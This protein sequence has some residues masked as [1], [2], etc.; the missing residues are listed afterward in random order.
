MRNHLAIAMIIFGAMSFS[1]AYLTAQENKPNPEIIATLSGHSDLVYSV[2][3][4]PDSKQVATG[5]F[6]NT[7]KLWEAPSGR[8]IKTYDGPQG[9]KKRVLCVA[10][11]GDGSQIASGSSDNSLKVWDVPLS[12]PLRDLPAPAPVTA[13][14][15]SPDNNKLAIG[16]KDGVI[17]VYNSTDYKELVKF[18]GHKGAL[19]SLAFSG[20]N[21]TLVSAGADKTLRIWNLGNKQALASIDAGPVTAVAVHPN[22]NA[23]YSAGEDG[24]LRFWSLPPDPKKLMPARVIAVGSGPIHALAITPNGSHVLTAGADKLVKMW[25]TGNGNNERTFAGAGG[26]LRALAVA[27]NNQWLAAGSDDKTVRLYNLGDAKQIGAVKTDAAITA[28]AFTPNNQTLAGVGADKTLLAWDLKGTPGQPPSPDFLRLVQKFASPSEI[29]GI[30]PARDSATFYTGSGTNAVHMWKLASALPTRNFGHPNNI[31]AVAFQPHGQLLASGCHD[32]HIR[33][34]DLIKGSQVRDIKAHPAQNAGMIYTLAFTPDGKQIVSG[35]Y[36]QTLKLWDV[37]SGKLVREFKAYKAKDFEK[38]HQDPIFSAAI[39]PDGKLLASGS[40]GLERI[41]KIWNLGD[42]AVVRDLVNPS[43]KAS[44]AAAHP[45]WVYSVAFTHDGKYL[46][47][48]GDAPVNKG[49][50][51]V[52]DPRA[53]KLLHAE[54]LPF[55]TFFSVAVASNGQFLALAA[56]PRGKT[57]AKLNNA[58]LLRMPKLAP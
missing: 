31:N 41:I 51:A 5:S 36:D 52:W 2:A 40:A 57:T 37:A 17:I 1:F 12:R 21:Q 7:V 32:G 15:L 6:D 39:S 35:G 54:T 58:Y 29:F 43:I 4:S 13:I 20:N 8:E 14:A 49:F 25:N 3:I 23:A 44:P 18:T 11:N 9:H 50:F 19:R 26:T 53:G 42:G 48:A 38:G 30:A 47:S 45:G 27:K 22:T 28:L 46:V 34:F 55:G 10:F 33:I 56:G 24:T 16:T